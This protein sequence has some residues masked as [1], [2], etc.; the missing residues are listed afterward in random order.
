[1]FPQL[2]YS[3][4]DTGR[5]G[6]PPPPDQS[7]PYPPPAYS[8]QPGYAPQ[9]GYGAE[10]G[11]GAQPGYGADQG[12]GA[13]HGG[14]GPPPGYAPPQPGYG[15]PPRPP[16]RSNIPI[17]AVILAVALLLCGGIVT[18]GVVAFNKA[19]ERTQEAIKP[20]TH[21]TFPTEVPNLPDI[22]TDI[23]DFPTDIPNLPDPNAS[24]K[25]IT[26]TYE[27]TGD[28]PASIV[29]TEKLG[30]S[31]KRVDDATLPWKLETTMEG[32]ALISVT[33]IRTGTDTGTITCRATVDGK[34]VAKRTRK[35]TF[36]TASCIKMIF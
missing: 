4:P 31:A 21:P 24:A 36:A 3:A 14:Y 35:G 32:A 27:V 19:K 22:P 5:G 23:P 7:Q 28:G 10:P 9:P 34:E 18:A 6:Y 25:K 13:Q 8:P 2:P 11:Y 16:K 15:P 33:G 20:I 1:M 12:Y 29:Y 30:D 26:V 17:V